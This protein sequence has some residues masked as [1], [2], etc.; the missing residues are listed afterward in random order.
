MNVTKEIEEFCKLADIT[1]AQFTG[2]EVIDDDLCIFDDDIII[3]LGFKPVVGGTLILENAT[4]IPAG[5]APTVG[6][7]LHLPWV[8]KIAKD[9]CP[10]VRGKLY[11]NDAVDLPA[12]FLRAIAESHID[13]SPMMYG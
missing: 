3:P 11:I 10:R 9:A 6:G 7:D 1:P 5:F 12:S 2:R 8:L 13:Y 4:S